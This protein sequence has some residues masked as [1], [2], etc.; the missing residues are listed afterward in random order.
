MEQ[1]SAYARHLSCL[2]APADLNAAVI[3]RSCTA[4]RLHAFASRTISRSNTFPR[5][6]ILT[7][8]AGVNA[9]TTRSMPRVQFAPFIKRREANTARLTSRQI[10]SIMGALEKIWRSWAELIKRGDNDVPIQLT[11]SLTHSY[12]TFN[13]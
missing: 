7:M 13:T 6:P 3:W 8:H 1:S 4:H 11:S 10:S 5:E 12:N 2:T 9:R